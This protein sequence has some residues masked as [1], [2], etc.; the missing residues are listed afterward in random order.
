M[1]FLR[2]LKKLF[3]RATR[4]R[5]YRQ[6]PRGIDLAYDL[7]RALPKYRMQTVFD[8]GANVGQSAREYLE[9]FP[10]AQIYS[11]EPVRSTFRQLEANLKGQDRVRCFQLAFGALPQQGTMVL[12]DKSVMSFLSSAARPSSGEEN[13][14]TEQ[15][16]VAT[17]DE[18]CRRHRVDRINYIKIDTE[19]GD[20]N[21]LQGAQQLLAEQSIDLVQLEAGMNIHNTWHV[22]LETLKQ[23]LESRNYFL[24]GVYEQVH[25]W[26]A[27]EPQLRRANPVFISRRMIET[28][29][30][31]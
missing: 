2:K 10:G 21:V 12:Q 3:E 28:H 26:P 30:G 31:A 1:N 5:I 20:M 24:F 9:K 14:I 7:A 27:K 11:F 17:L 6:P 23:Y 18:F 29:R 25:E 16:E 19:G 13:A 8:V 15:V 4:T 22:A